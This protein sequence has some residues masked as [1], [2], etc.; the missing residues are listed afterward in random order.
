MA[1]STDPADT[2][3][4]RVLDWSTLSTDSTEGHYR[5]AAFPADYAMT[6]D[7]MLRDESGRA[8]LL[9]QAEDQPI[10]IEDD[11]ANSLGM[12]FEPSQDYSWHTLSELRR[13]IYGVE[14]AV[15]SLH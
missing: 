6:D 5:V 9:S 13:I 3:A 12:F 7:V 8:F 10:P 15:I 4:G 2:Q 1:I 11:T 14:D